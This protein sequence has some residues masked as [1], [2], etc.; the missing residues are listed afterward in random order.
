ME[1]ETTADIYTENPFI[2]YLQPAEALVWVGRPDCDLYM[3][4]TWQGFRRACIWGGVFAM[5]ILAGMIYSPSSYERN[6]C[7]G[8]LAII[9]VSFCLAGWLAPRNYQFAAWYGLTDDHLFMAA[10]DEGS[11]DVHKIALGDILSI[12]SDISV[13]TNTNPVGETGNIICARRVNPPKHGNK[14][15]TL[16]LIK[17]PKEIEAL[18]KARVNTGR[19]VDTQI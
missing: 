7:I 1:I 13:D 4:R 18:I 3:R 14:N 8:L 15:I 9:F 12:N 19:S 6:I 2:K 11:L 17:R 10:I 16:E 5:V